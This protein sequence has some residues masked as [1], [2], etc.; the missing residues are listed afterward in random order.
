[1]EVVMKLPKLPDRNPVRI[2]FSAVPELN[3]ALQDYAAAYKLAYG[4]AAS[5]PD[6]IPSMLESF[7]E[8][9]REFAKARKAAS[10]PV[11]SAKTPEGRS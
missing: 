1:M 11:A 9:D 4:E 3:A 6:L 5:V 7:L 10:T 8:G 2:T